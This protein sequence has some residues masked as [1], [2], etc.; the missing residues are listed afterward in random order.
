MAHS[1]RGLLAPPE[2]GRHRS[3]RL[4]LACVVSKERAMNVDTQLVFSFSL[5]SRTP[6][7]GIALPT[8]TLGL[9]IAIN[10]I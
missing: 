2:Q 1:W 4:Q 7:H 10:L 3:L 6:A 8:S 9:H 5:Q